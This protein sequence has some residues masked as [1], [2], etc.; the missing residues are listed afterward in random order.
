MSDK[1]D[2]HFNNVFD[3]NGAEGISC[4]ARVHK[5]FTTLY[6]DLKKRNTIEPE[7]SRHIL[8]S[9]TLISLDYSFI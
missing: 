4:Y 9:E 2:I 3:F 8:R 1:Y 7:W 6:L 5:H